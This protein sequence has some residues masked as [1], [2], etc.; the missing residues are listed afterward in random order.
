MIR[1]FSDIFK[2]LHEQLNNL[3]DVF[4]HYEEGDL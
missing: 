2:N 4:A 3:E 1:R